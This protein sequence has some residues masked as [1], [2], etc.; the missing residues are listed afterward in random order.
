MYRIRMADL[1]VSF[2]W[3]H[4]ENRFNVSVSS[5]ADGCNEFRSKEEAQNFC[6]QFVSNGW[7][8]KGT[9]EAE[10]FRVEEVV[11]D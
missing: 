2:Y 10:R 1:Y 6:D 8:Y 11:R 7:Q 5:S 9:A 4:A 3:Q